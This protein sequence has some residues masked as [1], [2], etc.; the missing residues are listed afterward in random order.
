MDRYLIF[1]SHIINAVPVY[2][3]MK[4]WW[5]QHWGKCAKAQHPC[6]LILQ[7]IPSL[8]PQDWNCR[9]T[10][11]SLSFLGT[12]QEGSLVGQNHFCHGWRGSSRTTPRIDLCSSAIS[13]HLRAWMPAREWWYL[14]PTSYLFD[15]GVLLKPWALTSSSAGSQWQQQCVVAVVSFFSFLI[16]RYND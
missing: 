2:V 14:L 8:V 3:V 11:Q 16:A 12:N 5:E 13:Q 9:H 4:C 6:R 15:V 1:G 10:Q 7:P